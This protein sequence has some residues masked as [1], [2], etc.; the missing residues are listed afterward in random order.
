MSEKHQGLYL[1]TSELIH[2]L[3]VVEGC[4]ADIAVGKS[5]RENAL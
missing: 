3:D 5:V 1:E 4:Y 2:S